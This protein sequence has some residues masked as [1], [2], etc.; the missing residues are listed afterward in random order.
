MSR[1]GTGGGGT[2]EGPGREKRALAFLSRAMDSRSRAS[3]DFWVRRLG[4]LEATESSEGA[5]P[6]S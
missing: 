6:M 4:A 2:F 3:M 5:S 1:G